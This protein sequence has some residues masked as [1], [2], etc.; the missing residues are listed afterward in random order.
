MNDS[1][2]EKSELKATFSGHTELS[3]NEFV[4]IARTSGPSTICYKRN[5]S[6]KDNL[7]SWCCG[8]C[9]YSDMSRASR[10]LSGLQKDVIHLYRAV[11]R[12][13]RQKPPDARKSLEKYAGAEVRKNAVNVDRKDYQMIEYLLRKGTKQ[14]GS[15]KESTTTGFNVSH[16]L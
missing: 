9:L 2:L 3:C 15:L 16:K 4:F 12:A 8:M 14:L 10:P 7:R 13:A 11:L 5:H 6:R 1:L